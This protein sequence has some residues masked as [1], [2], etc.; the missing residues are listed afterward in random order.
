MEL[1]SWIL[2]PLN[3][4]QIIGYILQADVSEILIIFD[5]VEDR[6]PDW[7]LPRTMRSENFV[8]CDETS[9]ANSRKSAAVSPRDGSKVRQLGL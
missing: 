3:T 2:F 1:Q 6:S 9:D 8:A 4:V 5:F 7:H